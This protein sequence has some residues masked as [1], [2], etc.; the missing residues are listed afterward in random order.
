M[1]FREIKSEKTYKQII[2]QII[3]L[4]VKGDLKSGDKL[5]GERV[6]AESLAASR[7]S[8]REAF[9]TLEI[10]GILEVRHGGGTFVRD[11]NIAPFINTITPLFLQNIDIMGDMMDFRIMLESEAIIVAAVY[12][13]PQII[14]RMELAISNMCNKD[15]QIAEKADIDFHV[16]IFQATGNRVFV[17]AGQCLSYILYTSIHTSRTLLS[18]D[19]I[20]AKR[21]FDEHTQI[22]EAVKKH[23]PEQASTALINH[24]GFIR[25]YLLNIQK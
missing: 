19:K 14:D 4:I 18:D 24:L 17:F 2:D 5:P 20:I 16:S 25:T 7:S 23:Q 9:R 15:P 3:S 10:L 13:S 8:I 1:I 6:L 11:F 22:L 21:W 12:S